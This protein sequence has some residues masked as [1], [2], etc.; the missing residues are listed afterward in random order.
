MKRRKALKQIAIVSSAA[1]LWPGCNTVDVPSYSKT[2][3]DRKKWRIFQQFAEAVLP[4]DH[5]VYKTLE[6]RAQYI[7]N[8]INDCVPQ[9]EV[10]LF[11]DGLQH[12]QDYLNNNSFKDLATLSEEELDEI[13]SYLEGTGESD[14]ALHNF[15]SYTRELAKQHFT[16]SEK[17]MTEHLE[18]KFIPGDYL[19]CVNL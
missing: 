16:T 19:G 14:K 13:F 10:I 6:P 4:V 2:P 8:I 1:L 18:Y 12:L 11:N 17:Y 5:A 9:S 7:L 3:L 15:Y